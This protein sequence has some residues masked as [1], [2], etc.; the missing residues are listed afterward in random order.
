MPVAELIAIGTE[1]L[2]GEIQDTNTRYI[3]RLLRDN[4]IDLFRSSIVGD[5]PLRITSAIK[6]SLQRANIVITTGGLGPTVDDPTREAASCAWNVPLEF[7]PELWSQIEARFLSRGVTPTE[8]NRRQ[9]FLPAS[10]LSVPNPVGTA[11]AFILE[12]QEHCLICLPGVPREMET[13]MQLAVLPYLKKKFDLRGMIK[14][15]VLHLSGVGESKVDEQVS[16]FESL[17]NPTVGLLAHPGIVDIRITVK[18]ESET[19]ADQMIADLETTIRSRFPGDIFGVDG[20]TLPDTVL[21][22]VQK[23]GTPLTWWIKGMTLKDLGFSLPLPENFMLSEIN[24]SIDRK[25]LL[26]SLR[27]QIQTESSGI[28]ILTICEQS[29]EGFHCF[30]CIMTKK[31]EIS[32]EKIHNGPPAHNT[33]WA[34]NA[35]LDYL[36]RQITQ[37]TERTD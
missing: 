14:A 31:H 10:S 26:V 13:L 12:D 11:P 16:E 4:N 24:E 27:K 33:S 21:R 34:V 6:E 32:D 28:G 29:N 37:M 8:N 17:S 9:A 2:L 7:H 25:N 19:E 20:D 36:R 35:S 3:A 30:S 22:L 5:N 23:N 1:L 15:R 18:A